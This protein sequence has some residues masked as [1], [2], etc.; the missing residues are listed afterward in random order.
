LSIQRRAV[1][2]EVPR[3]DMYSRPLFLHALE[4][5]LPNVPLELSVEGKQSEILTAHILE[6]GLAVDVEGAARA[7]M[8]SIGVGG[9][10]RLTGK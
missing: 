10:V 5:I 4:V 7:A 9:Q 8:K 2:V 1:R 6:R 3:L